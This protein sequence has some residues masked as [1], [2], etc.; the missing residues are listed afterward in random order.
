MS[1]LAVCNFVSYTLFFFNKG[2]SPCSYIG[3]SSTALISKTFINDSTYS[4]SYIRMDIVVTVI[5]Q[6]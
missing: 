2:V 3:N 4:T 6:H 5:Q 1:Y